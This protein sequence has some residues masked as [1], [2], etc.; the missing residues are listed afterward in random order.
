MG[1]VDVCFTLDLH[2]IKR[3]I[4]FL[5]KEAGKITRI[6]QV[7]LQDHLFKLLPKSTASGNTSSTA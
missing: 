2:K 4:K 3:N 6:S 1:T 7:R 5:T